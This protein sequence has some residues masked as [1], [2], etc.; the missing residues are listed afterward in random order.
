MNV[1]DVKK[2]AKQSGLLE[3]IFDEIR[4]VD[5]IK[6]IILDYDN[7]SEIDTGI[8]CFDFWKKGEFCERCV[9]LRSL[10]EDKSYVKFGYIKDSFYM[11]ITAPFVLDGRKIVFEFI[12][13]ITESIVIDSVVGPRIIN[14][15]INDLINMI[16]IKALKDSVTGLYN[17]RYIDE[18][19]PIELINTALGEQAISIIMID[20]DNFKKINDEH[21]H[22]AGD[23]AL[24]TIGG[25]LKNNLLRGSDWVARFGGEEFIACLPGADLKKAVDIAETMR[26]AIEEVIVSYGDEKISFS[27]SFGVISL[28]PN[29]ACRAVDVLQAVD[30]M[31]YRAKVNGRNRVES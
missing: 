24:E 26:K 19:L 14:Q 18:R 30:E 3:N 12:K 10:A 22:L 21:G 15:E 20:I 23:K 4:I 13:N 29:V 28:K 7:G 8:S 5:P 27:A 9:S 17:R 2:A 6:K 25:I 1:A 16:S 11:V 31:L